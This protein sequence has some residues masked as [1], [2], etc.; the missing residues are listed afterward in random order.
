M[1]NVKAEK[2]EQIETRCWKLGH[3]QHQR[4]TEISKPRAVS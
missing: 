3:R 4:T 2:I 1:K